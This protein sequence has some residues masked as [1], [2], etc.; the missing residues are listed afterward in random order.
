MVTRTTGELAVERHEVVDGLD[1]PAA[2]MRVLH[3]AQPTTEGVARCVI[4]LVRDHVTRGWDVG[5]AC[6]TGGDLA[7]AALS[8][9]AQV[10]PW[11]ADR[12]P[13]PT[14]PGE[15]RRLH[16]IVQRFDPLVVHLHSAKAGLV[17]RLAMRG[18]RPTVFQPHA[19]SFLAVTGPLRKATEYWERA[20]LR[21]TDRVVCVS[22]SERGQ[23]SGSGL[24]LD[25]R[26]VVVPNGVDTKRF[27]PGDRHTA[28]VALGLGDE[29]LAVCVGRLSRQ[30]GQDVL[31]EA[32]PQVRSAVEGARLALVGDGP[33]K[34]RL[35]AAAP[36]DV[37]FVGKAD[38][39]LWY[40][41][42]DVVV[43]PSRWEGMA[44]VPLEAGACSRS[45]VL[46]DVAGSTESL[47]HSVCGAVV[48][49]EDPATLAEA[50]V[51]RLADRARADSE[52]A[53]I[54]EHVQAH[55]DI[56]GTGERMRRV[57]LEAI[58]QHRIM[59]RRRLR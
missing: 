30:K 24:R 28:R 22:E 47:P 42:A 39:L 18:H 50:I 3:V 59:Y 38:P 52:G 16:H 23:A 21:W 11:A 58:E 12:S 4:D 54:R 6:P 19:W 44:L 31:L 36:P 55:H 9:G 57:Y 46:T 14:V 40:R 26:A 15:A 8:A 35:V 53:A 45:V 17:G 34:D 1:I 5:V 20:A 2:G 7:T 56:R 27:S 48:R 51:A 33:D 29:P 10:F 43:L 41:A 25:D 32:W 13:G 49:P 37:S